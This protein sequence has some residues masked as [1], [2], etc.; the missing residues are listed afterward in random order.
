M[1]LIIAN[2]P[3]NFRIYV[4]IPGCLF[5]VFQDSTCCLSVSVDKSNNVASRNHSSKATINFG[6]VGY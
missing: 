4:C 5:I 2:L 1:L 3:A 6:L